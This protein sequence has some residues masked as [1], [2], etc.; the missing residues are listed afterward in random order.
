MKI[1]LNGRKSLKVNGWME[2]DLMNCERY[3][4][5]CVQDADN[6]WIMGSDET[7]EDARVRMVA[8]QQDDPDGEMDWFIIS[9][10]GDLEEKG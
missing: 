6:W 10:W 4:V 8:E 1:K 5:I 9:P 2:H 3:V 7:L